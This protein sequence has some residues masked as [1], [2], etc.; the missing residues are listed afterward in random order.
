M[1][2][3]SGLIYYQSQ[4]Y[5][6]NCADRLQA[7][8]KIVVMLCTKNGEL[9]IFRRK[10]MVALIK[11]NYFDTLR[12]QKDEVE[13]QFTGVD[14]GIIEHN[15]DYD[16]MVGEFVGSQDDY[17]SENQW[18][19][20]FLNTSQTIVTITQK[21]DVPRVFCWEIL[22]NDQRY[23]SSF[24]WLI[25]EYTDMN[26]TFVAPD[27]TNYGKVLNVA[28]AYSHGPYNRPR[29]TV[30]NWEHFDKFSVHATC[31]FF[32]YF[33][34]DRCIANDNGFFYVSSPFIGRDT[35]QILYPC[36]FID[37]LCSADENSIECLKLQFICY[38]DGFS[39]EMYLF[40]SFFIFSLC[41]LSIITIYCIL[42]RKLAE[43]QNDDLYNDSID[44][45]ELGFAADQRLAE[46]QEK[47]KRV[48]EYIKGN[49]LEVNYAD[50]AKTLQEIETC[51]IC[52]EEFIDPSKKGENAQVSKIDGVDK[53]E[54]PDQI[55]EERRVET[56]AIN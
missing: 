55:P 52:F 8:Q 47:L 53:E 5:A 26:V 42:K 2:K 7:S 30:A 13:P 21:G 37:Q 14:I 11:L 34:N 51:S 1:Y 15:V 25:L 44:L 48:Y 19:T 23:D 6:F 10:D 36:S 9:A 32:T 12:V 41:T 27:E 31:P 40:L 24:H 29:Y 16:G 3:S 43:A 46:Q 49:L 22:Q 54:D 17:K 56:A 38:E 39:K 35:N 4:D 18:M 20:D 33:K 45:M 50:N 28:S